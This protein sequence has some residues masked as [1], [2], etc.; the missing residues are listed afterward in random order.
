LK[1]HPGLGKS[2]NVQASSEYHCAGNFRSG[3]FTLLELLVVIAVIA[4]LAA[5]IFPSLAKSKQRAQGI[6]CLNNGKQ[7]MVALHLYADDHSGWLPPNPDFASSNR[8]VGGDMFVRV[9]A[10]NAQ[11][12]MDPNASRLARYIG[13]SAGIFKCPGDTSDQVRSF[14]MSQATGTK[15]L[16]PLAAVD[17]PWLDGTH[18]HLARKPWATYG[19]FNDMVRPSPAGLWMFMDENQHNINDAA[20][21]VSMNRPTTMID[22][23]G[24]Y[25]SS[26]A[27]LA[28]ADGHS[29]IH[30][31][32]DG[33]TKINRRVRSRPHLQTPDN[34][35]IVWLQQRTS[36]KVLTGGP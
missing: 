19:K 14:S 8:W 9:E 12:L 13:G 5:L 27:G 21:A 6:Y 11:I 18:R 28:F 24:T 32:I 30:R 4:I 7:L 29:E 1:K 17:G 15:P 10:T 25:H 35:D 22:W 31:W 34:P 2:T 26:A 16:P 20:F 33:R 36:A 3:G 23:P